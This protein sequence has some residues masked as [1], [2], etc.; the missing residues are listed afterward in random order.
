MFLQVR[1]FNLSRLS[2]R[3]PEDNAVPPSA[4]YQC[5]TRRVKKLAVRFW[6]V[7]KGYIKSIYYTYSFVDVGMF[8]V[9]CISNLSIL[10]RVSYLLPF[11]IVG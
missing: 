9:S 10:A 5:H 6:D 4:L 8:I 2:G 7:E 3:G 11:F 1:L